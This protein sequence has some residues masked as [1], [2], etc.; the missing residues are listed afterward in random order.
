MEISE[1]APVRP[2][3]GMTIS[4]RTRHDVVVTDPE[5]FL[6]AARRA[7][8]QAHPEVSASEAEQAVTDVYDAVHAFLDR[9]GRLGPPR[10]FP[11]AGRGAPPRRTRPKQPYGISPAGEITKIVLS[12]PKP[13]QDR[14]CLLPEDPSALPPTPG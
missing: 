1:D 7:Y 12:D 13:L 5:R 10:P 14:G 8:R 4:V 2:E 11:S 3:P 6:A 9:D